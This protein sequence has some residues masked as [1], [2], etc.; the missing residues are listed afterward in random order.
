[1]TDIAELVKWLDGLR[2]SRATECGLLLE[3]Q[4]KEIYQRGEALAHFNHELDVLRLDVARLEGEVAA[5]R[6]ALGVIA[7][8]GDGPVVR[9]GFDCPAHATLARDTLAKL[10]KVK[11]AK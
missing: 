3:A 4:A 10:A 6:E 2:Q 1:M 9:S 7:Q 8:W 11:E 5:A